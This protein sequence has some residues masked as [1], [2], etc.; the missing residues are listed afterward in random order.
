MKIKTFTYMYIY[1]NKG[2]SQDSIHKDRQ[3]IQ[4]DDRYSNGMDIDLD[5]AD[6]EPEE[7]EIP[8]DDRCFVCGEGTCSACLVDYS[9]F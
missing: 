8:E 2:L 9:L 6:I 3:S 1:R 5:N 7:Y 4:L